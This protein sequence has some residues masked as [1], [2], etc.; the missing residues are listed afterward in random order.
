MDEPTQIQP[1]QIAYIVNV[2]DL[3]SSRFVKESGWNPSYV[4]I[5]DKN[6]SRINVIGI[7][8]DVSEENNFQNI[9]VDDGTG[10]ISVRNF[11]KRADVA[12][13]NIVLVVG[14][15][16][17]YGNE[18]YVVPEIIKN[19]INKKWSLL[20]K[21][22][23]VKNEGKN[24]EKQEPVSVSEEKIEE[25]DKPKSEIEKIIEKIRELDD[26]NGASYAELIKEFKDEKLISNLL[27]Q[28]EIFEIKPGRLKVLD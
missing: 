1:R 27:L 21:R 19:N 7:I 9:V 25:I 10:R 24:I 4:V 6:V 16:R 23:A 28:G 20:W 26:G 18:K 8:T 17:Q 2:N 22:N 13:G 11:E 14:R 3:L 5:A 15:I 12:I